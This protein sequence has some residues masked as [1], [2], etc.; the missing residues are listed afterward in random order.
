MLG[1]LFSLFACEKTLIVKS[2]INTDL[3]E[4][5]G[6]DYPAYL[7]KTSASNQYLFQFEDDLFFFAYPDGYDMKIYKMNKKKK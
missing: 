3:V 2:N 4:N 7:S 5:W 6:I 1:V